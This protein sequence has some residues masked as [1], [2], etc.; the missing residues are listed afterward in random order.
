MGC[1]RS[2]LIHPLIQQRQAHLRAIPCDKAPPGSNR[3][4]LRLQADQMVV[5]GYTQSIS[6]E[7]VGQ[8]L[9]KTNLQHFSG[10]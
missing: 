1:A 6:H 2:L 7:R 9:K 3:W 4:T 10:W 8:V 5:L